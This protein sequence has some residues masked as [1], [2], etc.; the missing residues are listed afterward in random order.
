MVVQQISEALPYLEVWLSA[1]KRAK[2]LPQEQIHRYLNHENN[3]SQQSR[4][5]AAQPPRR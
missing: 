2:A 5:M 1:E 4:T 3:L